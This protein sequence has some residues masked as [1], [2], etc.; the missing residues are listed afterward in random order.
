MSMVTLPRLFGGAR[1]VRLHRRHAMVWNAARGQRHYLHRGDLVLGAVGGPVGIFR[2]DHV[3][4]A[5]RM[6]ERGVY[7][8][9]GDAI[10]DQRAQ[11][12]RASTAADRDPAAVANSALFGV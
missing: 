8:P 2:G 7:D 9:W 6:M 5:L 4:A 1:R 3:G 11:R 12:D 10:G